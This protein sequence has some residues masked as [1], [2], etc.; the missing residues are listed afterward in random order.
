LLES[1]VQVVPDS[2]GMG[3]NFQIIVLSIPGSMAAELDWHR[4]WES[5]RSRSP[6]QAFP[7]EPSR[8]VHH[9][10]RVSAGY[11]SEVVGLIDQRLWGMLC[12]DD[13]V[14]R[15]GAVLDIGCGTG[16]L[17]ERFASFGARAVGLDISPGMLSKAALRCG[18]I[19]NVE[20]ICQDWNEFSGGRDYD[21]VFSSFCPAV[22]GLPSLMKMEALSRGRCCLVSLGGHSG[23]SLAFDIWGDLGHAGMSLEGYDPLFPYFILKDMGRQPVLKSFDVCEESVVSQEDMVEHLASYFSLFQ[24]ITPQVMS[25]IGDR[26]SPRV[27]DGHLTVRENR[28]VSVLSWSPSGAGASTEPW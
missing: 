24:E 26:V 14:P 6:Y 2:P 17:T 1:D 20:L 13:L 12:Q 19:R 23:D 22:D 8:A 9:W 21:L 10:D 5:A 4:A 28:T 25:A 18:R 16:A 11:D 27:R 15:N 3:N 7:V